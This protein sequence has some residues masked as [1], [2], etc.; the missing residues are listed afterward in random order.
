MRTFKSLTIVICIIMTVL[1]EYAIAQHMLPQIIVKLDDKILPINPVRGADGI[2]QS[3]IPSIDALNMEFGCTGIKKLY[4][5]PH[6]SGRGLYVFSFPDDSDIESIAN[7]FAQNANVVSVGINY[8]IPVGQPRNEPNDNLFTSEQGL[9]QMDAPEAWD[10]ETGSANVIIQIND[11][12]VDFL[13]WG[14]ICGKTS[15]KTLMETA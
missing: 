15:A 11:T 4:R 6:P 1:S 10:V 8:Q 5:G 2:W 9:E 3:N 14:P 13:I 12:G 7:T